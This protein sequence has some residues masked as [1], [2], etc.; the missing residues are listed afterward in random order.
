MTATVLAMIL[1]STRA[2]A[3]VQ[4]Q[5]DPVWRTTLILVLLSLLSF[6]AGLGRP[7]IGDSDEAF[8]AE[9][10]REMVASGDWL[11]PHYNYEPRFQKPILFYWLVA[12]T[13]AVAGVSEAGARVWSA[14]AGLGLA[15]LTAAC[16]R[17]WY[18]ERTGRLA[19]AVVA[20]AFGY[21]SIGRLSLPDLPLAFFITL[22]TWAAMRA[23]VDPVPRP[24]RWLMLAG[25]A[26]GLGFLTKG[27][28]AIVLPALVVLP[29][30]WIEQRRAPLP[31]R[32]LL[33]AAMVA[34][35]VG[36][37]WYVAMTQ[38]HGQAYLEGFFIG[39]NV[40][41]FATSRFNEPRSLWFYVPI[42]AGGM[43]PW[44]PLVACGV[45]PALAWLRRQARPDATA[46]RLLLWALLPLLFFT[47]SVGKQPRY[48]LP[49]LPPLAL[50]LAHAVE[51]RLRERR[52][53]RDRVL[54]GA[55][56][57]TG[58]L[59]MALGVLIYRAKPLVVM[60]D[61]R[62]I[63]G[64]AV[65]ILVA[66]AGTV[67][68]ALVIRRDRLPGAVAVAAV[69]ALL[70]LQY[71]LSPAGRDPVQNMAGLVV[72]HRQGDEPVGTFRVFVRNLIFYT[73][74]KRTDL[75]SDEALR[76]YLRRPDRVLCVITADEL[77]RMRSVEAVP[78]RTLAEVLYFNASAVKLRTLL[79]P[80]P[81]RDLERVLLITNR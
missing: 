37:P 53:G 62:L 33:V 16:G 48:V 3:V 50:L 80:D 27:P 6:F 7:A 17:A 55:T 14:M 61:P 74:V 44:T 68:A 11:T 65:L 2:H 19:G 25:L 54:R 72:A 26:A 60:V 73:H 32:G 34:F 69:A 1:R 47:A 41:R 46:V 9:A 21:F 43:L 66:G 64:G 67:A 59:L 38:V 23:L 40:D 22:T 42:V 30:W 10:G 71:G 49:I 77:A 24:S 29:V 70:G 35:V 81:E 63:V 45:S 28:V 4:L 56:I 75:P 20:T 79:S 36:A 51:G 52:P 13:Y 12:G 8:Y 78:V 76:D 57:V 31:V 15:L 5:S 58:A 39:D 18:G